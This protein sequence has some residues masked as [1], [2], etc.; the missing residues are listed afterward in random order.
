[1]SGAELALVTEN[2]REF[3]MRKQLDRIRDRFDYIVIDCPPSLGL[4]TVNCLTSSDYIII[5]LQCEYYAMEGL[6]Q[7][8]RTFQLVKEN[9]NP[10][11]EIGGVLLTMADFRTNLTQQVIQE[12]RSYFDDKVFK[13]VIPR[14]IKVSEAP[15]FG[16]P[17]VIYDSQSKGSKCYQEM[18]REFMERFPMPIRSSAEAVLAPASRE[19]RNPMLEPSQT[20]NPGQ[21]HEPSEASEVSQVTPSEESKL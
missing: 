1:L 5:P 19:H 15:S 4:M 13:T 21:P 3:I 20:T 11:L 6:G 2:E 8:L 9:L 16:M 17:A 14:S 7:L 12:V 18:G 10:E